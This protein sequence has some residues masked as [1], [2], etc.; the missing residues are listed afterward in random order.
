MNDKQKVC[1]VHTET[2]RFF[3]ECQISYLPLLY[4]IFG[5]YSTREKAERAVWDYFTNRF[6]EQY[7]VCCDNF[8]VEGNVLEFDLCFKREDKI[9]KGCAFYGVDFYFETI[10]V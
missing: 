7:E 4:P 6:K 5:V 10:D 9:F 2:R 3:D 8:D 1:V